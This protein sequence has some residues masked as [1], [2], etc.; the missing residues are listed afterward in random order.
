MKK[1]LIAML[2]ALSLVGTANAAI[3]TA[4]G[5]NLFVWDD[6]NG[7]LVYYERHGSKD[8]CDGQRDI[9]HLGAGLPG[10]MS[11]QVTYKASCKA[12]EYQVGPNP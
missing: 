6:S 12:F 3:T 4:F 11:S 1:T 2:A 7:K 10:G 9:W 5:W 8:Y